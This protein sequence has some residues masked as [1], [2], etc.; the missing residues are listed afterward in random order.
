M[1]VNCIFLYLLFLALSSCKTVVTTEN[2]NH[3]FYTPS[4]SSTTPVDSMAENIIEPYRDL[5]Q[6]EMNE[7]IA[8]SN[9][10]LEKGQ[11]ESK[12]GNFVADLCFE[13]GI[14]LYMPD[15]GSAIDIC[16]LNNGGLRSS[17]PEGEIK[18]KNIY[19][20]MPFDNELVVLK[21]DGETTNELFEYI[22]AKGGVPV[23]NLRMN[24]ADGKP[25]NIL[26]GTDKFDVSKS[27]YILTSD[28]LANGGD[29]MIMFS[30]ATQTVK[31][32]IKVRDAII[33]YLAEIDSRQQVLNVET[34]GR[35]TK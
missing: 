28:Y 13:T 11:P 8:S 14:K 6:D 26:I 2:S 27:Y 32:G 21:L 20:L 5:L 29:S 4:A 1:K 25:E 18:L 31:L 16:I 33:S 24:I 22:A 3:Q 19:E 34:D 23:A 9:H 7:V 10:S 30:K 12:L 15:D 17:L 35:I